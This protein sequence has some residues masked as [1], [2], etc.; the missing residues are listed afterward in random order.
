MPQKTLEV[1]NLNVSYF[2][3]NRF[4]DAVKDLNFNLFAGEIL[5]ILGESGAGKSTVGWALMRMIDPPHR[6]SGRIVNRDQDVMSMSERELGEYRWRRAAMIF[7]TAMNSLDPVSTVGRSFRRLLLDKQIVKSGSEA[8]TMVGELLDMVGLTPLV[9]DMYPFELSGGMKQRVLI[10][11]ALA[12]RPDVLIAD[13]PTTALDTLTQFS[14]LN[15]MLDLRKSDR[16]GSMIFISHDLSVQAFMADRVMVMLK[17]RMVELGSK[18]DVFGKPAHPYTQFLMQSLRFSFDDTRKATGGGKQGGSGC[19][20][21]Q[22]CAHAME[23]CYQEFPRT[24]PLSATHSV[25]CHLYGE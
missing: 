4:V 1:E 10:A 18:D 24:T 23:R 6:V 3:K 7:Q 2:I 14:I 17:G 20:F 12:A 5:G 16:I 13:E 19:P 21:A 25:A 22:F 8:Q 11:M 9:A 15:T